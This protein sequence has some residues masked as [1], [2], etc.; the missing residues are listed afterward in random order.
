MRNLRQTVTLTGPSGTRT[1]VGAGVVSSA[2]AEG[3]NALPGDTELKRYDNDYRG[4]LETPAGVPGVIMVSSSGNTI[5]PSEGN[6]VPEY[7]PPAGVQGTQDNLAYYSSYGE[8]VDISAPGGARK[9]GVPKFD[10]RPGT[11]VLYGGWGQLGASVKNGEI[12]K[13]IGSFADFACFTS[14][15]ATFAWLQGTSMSSPQVAGVAALVM[16]AHPELQEHPDAVLSRLQAT[17]R[18]GLVNHTGKTSP[19]TGAAWNGTPCTVGYCHVTFTESETEPNAIPFGLA[20]G[21]GMVDAAAGV[22]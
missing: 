17:A 20:Y 6:V 8:R 3:V 11:D 19:S 21:A 18:T 4:M 5:A 10:T 9:Y 1:I 15:N 22:S 12:C 7:T 13:T 14:S 2:P 16:A